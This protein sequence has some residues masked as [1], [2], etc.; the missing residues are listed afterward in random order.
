MIRR[1]ITGALA[2]IGIL[3]LAAAPIQAQERVRVPREV[4]E[5][6]C[7]ANW[8]IHYDNPTLRAWQTGSFKIRVHSG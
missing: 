8:T 4:L 6:Y 1:H 3:A 2:I 5:K 7:R